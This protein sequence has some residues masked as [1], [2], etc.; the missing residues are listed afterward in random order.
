MI[1]SEELVLT[2]QFKSADFSACLVDSIEYF[3]IV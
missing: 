1:H 2:E 3:I